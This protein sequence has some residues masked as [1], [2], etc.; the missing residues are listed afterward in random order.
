MTHAVVPRPP[1]TAEPV[2]PS[3][4]R[5]FRVRRRLVLIVLAVIV[6]VAAVFVLGM[7]GLLPFGLLL[8]FSVDSDEEE[9]R[10]S[11]IATPR[12]LGLAAVMV[13]ALAWF[14]LWYR[15]SAPIDAGVDR[16]GRHRPAGRA[17]G[18][19]RH[20]GAGA[21]SCGHETQ[22]HPGPVGAG[23]LHLPLPGQGNMVLWTGGGMCRAAPRVGVVAGLGRPPGPDRGRAAPPPA[24]PRAAGPPGAG[25]Q[26][27]VVLRAARWNRGRRR[28]ALRADR[29]L[30]E[31]RPVQPS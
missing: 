27:L 28:H 12:N 11:V 8:A 2:L 1:S 5:Q 17:P 24:S 20:C 7:P 15:R 25:S 21:H 10:R 26:H 23:D 14:W 29:V 16:R 18:V 22:P 9:A 3:P 6:F 4:V 31:R 13:A 19:R 30:L